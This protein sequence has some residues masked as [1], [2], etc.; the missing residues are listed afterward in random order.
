MKTKLHAALTLL[1]VCTTA[2]IFAQIPNSGFENWTNLGSYMEANGWPSANTVSAGIF[3]PVTRVA[4]PHPTT[5]G[6]YSI[7]IENKPSL[8]PNYEAYGFVWNNPI[9]APQPKPAFPITGHPASLTGYY[10]FL[11][12]NNDTMYVNVILYLNGSGVSYSHFTTTSTVSNWTSFNIPLNTYTTADSGTIILAAFN[13]DGPSY[14]PH[15]NSV[16]SVDNLNFD[17]L[18]TGISD[19]DKDSGISVFLNPFS[20]Q[21]TLKSDNLLIK[22]TLTTYNLQGQIVKQITPIT[23][24]AGQT[25][26][27]NSDNLATGTY[28]LQ[29]TQENK[30]VTTKKIFITK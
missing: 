29:L 4:D 12:Q 3:Y 13:A 8:L 11:P 15:G 14:V 9:N 24:G 7:R 28:F 6:S 18:I 16:L 20:A 2:N 30:V 10:K 1:F 21:I 22:A 23:I 27:L 25:V 19:I 17:N 26:I 5:V